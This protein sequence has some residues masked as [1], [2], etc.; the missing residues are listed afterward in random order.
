MC[1]NMSD[2]KS[3][4]PSSRVYLLTALA[5]A[6]GLLFNYLFFAKLPG[7]SVVIFVAIVIALTL[8]L[9]RR[10]GTP[11]RAGL[12]LMGAAVVFSLF[13]MVRDN[14]FL[15]FLNI[16]TT[17]GLLLLAIRTVTGEKVIDFRIPDYLRTIFWLPFKILR[18]SLEAI[19]LLFRPGQN[20]PAGR[21]TSVIK[22]IVMALPFLVI[23][24]L[25]FASADAAFKQ[26][27]TSI[28]TFTIPDTFFG[29]LVFIIGP[30][31]ISLG[32]WALLFINSSRKESAA[33]AEPVTSQPAGSRSLET[34]IFLWLIAALFLIFIIFQV[35]YLFGGAINIT[36]AG[37]TYAEY[38]RRG[39]WEL[40]VVAF[41][42]LLI[43]LVTD[44]Y[45][46]RAQPR[47]KWFTLPSLVLIGEIFI[48][49]ISSFKRLMLYQSAY[50]LTTLR[51]YV[52][53]FI[54]FLAVIFAL[55]AFKLWREKQDSFFAFAALLVMI[56]FLLGMNV[57]NPDS[58]IIRQ[59][60]ARFDKTGTI[61]AEYLAWQR[62]A[63]AVPALLDVS[64]RLSQAAQ[65]PLR[66]SLEA[67]KQHLEKASTH[68]ESFNLS[69]AGALTLLHEKLKK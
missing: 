32:V 3:I 42:T 50:G 67:I 10:H 39:F 23:F 46:K 49:M 53:G 1:I 52:A 54:I 68:W 15:S 38:A 29:H 17:L 47:L 28:F 64:D 12:W 66:G 43:L 41:I 22:G 36:A 40:L 16:L 48:I 19:S 58:F 37:F 31:V 14:G 25:L 30:F 33:S 65:E 34:S 9:C 59:N 20:S 2:P 21:R 26:F 44:F 51:L 45:T 7:V 57:L 62:S 60:I 55:L 35:A 4:T 56:A 27:F 24:G 18:R 5:F 13:V 6:L 11:Y 69:R 61:D 63:D 8:W